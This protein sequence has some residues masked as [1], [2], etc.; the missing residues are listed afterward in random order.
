VADDR[1]DPS[2]Q[3][4]E[5]DLLEQQ[6]P[7]EPSLTDD[8]RSDDRMAPVEHV[9]E[10]DRWEQQVPVPSADDDYPMTVSR[11]VSLMADRWSGR[12]TGVCRLR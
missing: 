9:D 6:V 8:E 12:S 3:I 2:E 7:I 10:A 5:A 4:P 1:L 11:P